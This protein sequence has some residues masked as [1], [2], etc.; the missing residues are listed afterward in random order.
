MELSENKRTVTAE[1]LA[2]EYRESYCSLLLL[3]RDDIYFSVVDSKGY[4]SLY[5]RRPRFF[6]SIFR[7]PNHFLN[8][9]DSVVAESIATL[10][11]MDEEVGFLS[12][13]LLVYFHDRPF[14]DGGENLAV[15]SIASLASLV[16]AKN[17]SG[18]RQGGFS[19]VASMF[20]E[21]GKFFMASKGGHRPQSV[22]ECDI[23]SGSN[24]K[25]EL[26]YLLASMSSWNE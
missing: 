2:V 26:W 20:S 24:D 12:K 13:I 14:L 22:N 23:Y 18:D 15:D 3:S 25:D 19:I 11:F 4:C 1:E 7:L 5:E 8:G 10:V 21:C 9:G 17:K 6:W 16:E